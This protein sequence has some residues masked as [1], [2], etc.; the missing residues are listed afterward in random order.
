MKHLFCLILALSGITAFAQQSTPVAAASNSAKLREVIFMT[1]STD[2]M[3][4]LS[5]E[6]GDESALTEIDEFDLSAQNF[7]EQ[8]ELPGVN[9]RV[10]DVREVQLP[11]GDGKVF[12][13]R[14]DNENNKFLIILY[15]GKKEPMIIKG[16]WPVDDLRGK[17]R[18]Y[19]G[20]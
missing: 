1:Y 14:R 3:V 18:A 15:D 20:L 2:E 4:A 11:Y 9:V 19:F 16:I 7:A 10:T 6:A 8:H 12:S 13:A 17:V 5:T